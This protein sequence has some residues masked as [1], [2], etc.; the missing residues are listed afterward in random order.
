MA[1][2]ASGAWP[3]IAQYPAH[4]GEVAELRVPCLLAAGGGGG[5]AGY[6]VRTG[7]VQPRCMCATRCV[8][9]SRV[10]A[11]VALATLVPICTLCAY[12]TLG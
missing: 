12:A 10:V 2:L 8:C 5:T 9:I 6:E 4:V 11:S 1:W 3:A 7:G